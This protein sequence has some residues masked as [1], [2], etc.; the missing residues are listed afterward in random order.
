M[1]KEERSLINQKI[2][3]FR[4]W[5]KEEEEAAKIENDQAEKEE[6][7]LQSRLSDCAANT[8][9][10]LIIDLDEIPMSK[11]ESDLIQFRRTIMDLYQKAIAE[12][13]AAPY[14]SITYCTARARATALDDALMYFDLYTE[15][16]LSAGD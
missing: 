16:I 10:N 1:T 15:S 6:K 12:K 2:D 7:Y 9:Y 3:Q 5:A 13:E 11:I 4:T 8:L 14:P